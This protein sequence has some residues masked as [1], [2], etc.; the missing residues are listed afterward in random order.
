MHTGR[1][2]VDMEI[3]AKTFKGKMTFVY[4]DKTYKEA[5]KLL[6]E[7]LRKSGWVEVVELTDHS[8]FK[9]MENGQ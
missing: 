3:T 6:R 4:L 8:Q 2:E 1:S 9:I 5:K 7:K